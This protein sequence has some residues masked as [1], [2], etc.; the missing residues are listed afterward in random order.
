MHRDRLA[1]VDIVEIH[2]AC[3]QIAQR[4]QL[5]RV[6][7][8][9]RHHPGEPFKKQIARRG[10]QA[11]P[12]QHPVKRAA[13]QRRGQ[14]RPAD[15]TPERFQCGPRPVGTAALEPVGQHGGVHGTGAGAADL[16]DLQPVVLQEPVQNAPGQRPVRPTALKRQ[17]DLLSG[18]GAAHVT[19][20]LH[21]S[22][23]S[24]NRPAWQS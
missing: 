14:R 6:Q 7:L 4:I 24:P 17:I 2:Q 15:C 19:S 20:M 13:L 8:I 11:E 5:H 9:G 16:G 23:D 18:I 22:D 12:S 21:C 1:A 10:I 3:H